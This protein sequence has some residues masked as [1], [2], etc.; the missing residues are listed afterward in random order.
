M[1]RTAISVFILVAAALAADKQLKPGE[2]DPYNAVIVDLNTNKFAKAIADL[3]TWKQKF[4]ETDYADER[5]ALSVQAF[6]GAEKP[7]ETLAAAAPLLARD[8]DS[9]FGPDGQPTVIRVLYA[10]V[11]AVTQSPDLPPDSLAAGEKAARLLD[12][13]DHRPAS[14]NPEQWSTLRAEM[15]AKAQS[16]LL[17]IAVL[18]GVRAMASKPP[19]CAAAETVY[20]RALTDH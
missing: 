1:S 5:S 12:A 6:A 10:A 15:R 9:V 2:Y 8:L 11:W 18:P 20:T 13:Y 7:A 3:D 4:P 16:A 17:Y 19:D 14:V